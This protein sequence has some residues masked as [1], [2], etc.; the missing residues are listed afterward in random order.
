MEDETVGSVV[1]EENGSPEGLVTD[2]KIA[3]EMGHGVDG[4]APVSEIM[5]TDLVTAD[6]D[7][8]VFEV[9]RTMSGESIRRCPVVENGELAGIVTLDDMVVLLSDE[10]ANVSEVITGQSPPY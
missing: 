6:A 4:G 10:L 5:T 7:D 1:I 2:R 9:L 3:M 8:G